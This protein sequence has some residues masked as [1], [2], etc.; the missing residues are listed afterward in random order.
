MMWNERMDRGNRNGPKKE[1]VEIMWKN[2]NFDE[3]NKDV[4][5]EKKVV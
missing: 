1:G 2:T 4:K 5:T 3:G